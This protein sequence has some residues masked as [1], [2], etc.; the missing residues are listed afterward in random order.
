MASYELPD[1]QLWEL[2]QVNNRVE[3][4]V[5]TRLKRDQ[6]IEKHQLNGVTVVDPA[7]TYI[8]EDVV[9][10]ADTVI[11]PCTVISQGVHIGKGCEIGPFAH[12][13]VD[14]RLEDGVEIGN[15]TEV[16][17]TRL[18][19]G[20]KAK[21]LSYLGDGEVGEK[22]NIG[23]GTIFANYDGT[24]KNVTTIEDGAFIGSG[25]ILV[26]PVTVGRDASTGAGAVVVRGRD[27]APGETVVGVPARQ[28]EKDK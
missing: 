18:R 15:F 28:L 9:I 8:D 10:G 26:A 22:V 14:A 21:H 20:S 13:R 5:A 19:R 23:A 6:I 7:T 17:K 2:Q 24:E 4:A 12:L 1:S 11:Q 25:T 27:V 3:L 16:K